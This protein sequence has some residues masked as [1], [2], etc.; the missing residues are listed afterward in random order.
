MPF[1]D[2]NIVDANAACGSQL[3][4]VTHAEVNIADD[5]GSITPE[6]A[7]GGN[8]PGDGPRWWFSGQ[9]TI[10]CDFGEPPVPICST[11]FGKGGYVW[12]T[13]KRSNPDKVISGV[14]HTEQA[15]RIRISHFGSCGFRTKRASTARMACLVRVTPFS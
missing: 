3:Y 4:V 1:S 5:A 7:F 9:Y 12:T 11:A 13:D 2:L 10:C 14:F 15:G 8:V 6:T